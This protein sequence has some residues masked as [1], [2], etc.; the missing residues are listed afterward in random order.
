MPAVTINCIKIVVA[1]IDVCV[2]YSLSHT[3]TH[4]PTYTAGERGRGGSDPAHRNHIASHRSYLLM[5]LSTN[6]LI[7]GFLHPYIIHLDAHSHAHHIT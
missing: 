2:L 6:S 5:Y 1:R 3:H 4:K 7:F